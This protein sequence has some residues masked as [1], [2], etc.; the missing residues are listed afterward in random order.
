[1]RANGPRPRPYRRPCRVLRGTS[2]GA[3]A[4]QETGQSPRKILSA[5]ELDR[6]RHSMQLRGGTMVVCA[7]SGMKGGLAWGRNVRRNRV[8]DVDR[9]QRS[10]SLTQRPPDT[11]SAS[12]A[13]T[14][15]SHRPPPAKKNRRTTAGVQGRIPRA[16]R[17]ANWPISG[18]ASLPPDTPIARS[19]G[20]NCGTFRRTNVG[21]LPM[22]DP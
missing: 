3:A 22:A 1:M 15:G 20:P 8:P 14:D 19:A 2:P 21:R 7:A 16:A 13:E 18:T 5:P 11:R 12:C 10:R 6:A 9:M 4:P 17:N